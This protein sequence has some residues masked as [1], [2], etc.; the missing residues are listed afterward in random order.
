MKGFRAVGPPR[1]PVGVHHCRAGKRVAI[2]RRHEE[3][4]RSRSGGADPDHVSGRDHTADIE[5]A[6]LGAKWKRSRHEQRQNDRRQDAGVQ[7]NNGVELTN[8]EAL[9]GIA[10][11]LTCDPN[12]GR[13]PRAIRMGSPS[14]KDENRASGV[15][16][17]RAGDAI[18]YN[19]INYS[20]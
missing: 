7:S 10:R 3:R 18:V 11:R 15:T 4:D 1:Q 20:Y 13:V 14:F 5:V 12:Q 19:S 2:T 16:R 6:R 9:H 8:G 17:E